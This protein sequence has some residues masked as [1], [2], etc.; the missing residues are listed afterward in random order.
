[1]E[2][3]ATIASVIA[4]LAAVITLCFTLKTSRANIRKKIARKNKK[5][6]EIDR[7]IFLAQSDS[8]SFVLI[9]KLEAKKK[10]LQSDVETLKR[11]L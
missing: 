8:V 7:Q 9:K 6:G 11:D 10:E 1:M 3:I 4:A 2:I 5:I